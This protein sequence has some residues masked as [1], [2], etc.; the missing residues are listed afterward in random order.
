MVES[1]ALLVDVPVSLDQSPR[2]DSIGSTF[3][4]RA[5]GMIIRIERHN[6]VYECKRRLTASACAAMVWM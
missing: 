1:I 4:A 6:A 2:S 5:A 3:D